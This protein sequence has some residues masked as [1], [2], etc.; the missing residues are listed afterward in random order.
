MH[1]DPNVVLTFLRVCYSC[2]SA[3]FV[4]FPNHQLFPETKND[5]RVTNK[6]LKD[7]V[8][9]KISLF[10]FRVELG[11]EVFYIHLQCL[12]GDTQLERLEP[13]KDR[14]ETF[15]GINEDYPKEMIMVSEFL[16]LGKQQ[17]AI[18][19]QWLWRTD[20]SINPSIPLIL[21]SWANYLT[22]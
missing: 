5:S 17:N 15:L 7:I 6:I 10:C 22:T 11:W 13:I 12:W 20:I 3:I 2:H 4:L 14:I 1:W 18:K 21:S 19:E 8:L 16:L 9:H